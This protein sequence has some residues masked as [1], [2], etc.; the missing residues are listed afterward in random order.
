MEDETPVRPFA[1]LQLIVLDLCAANET[2]EEVLLRASEN[3]KLDVV[4]R[5]LRK[6]QNPDGRGAKTT[7]APIHVASLRGHLEVVRL[8]LEAGADQNSTAAGETAALFIA[9][10]G[11]HIGIVQLLVEAGA[12]RDAATAG[13]ATALS[14][15]S[16]ERPPEKCAV[17]DRVWS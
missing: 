3:N 16:S 4:E 5:L 13:G 12:G 9:A 11:G 1:S 14:C 10:Q 8:L 7:Y 6:P 15:C 17:F 2:M